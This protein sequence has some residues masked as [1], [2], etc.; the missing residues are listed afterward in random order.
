MVSFGGWVC[1]QNLTKKF[2]RN[3]L[4]NCKRQDS[5]EWLTLT[6]TSSP[7]W[8]HQLQRHSRGGGHSFQQR[9]NSWLSPQIIFCNQT[10]IGDNT[11]PCSR[12][13]CWRQ[14]TLESQVDTG[15]ARCTRYSGF[16]MSPDR[17]GIVE[18][19]FVFHIRKSQMD[20]WWTDN[21]SIT[22]RVAS[23]TMMQ[24]CAWW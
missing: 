2:R 5:Y 16:C 1:K 15:V 12:R 6:W 21:L 14:A 22:L 8:C 10:Q 11:P 9:Q 18:Y 17:E 23:K 24:A 4:K 19:A 3:L 13:F 7:H 20:T